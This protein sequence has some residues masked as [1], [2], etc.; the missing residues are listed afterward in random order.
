M[1]ARQG[2]CLIDPLVQ[3][4]SIGQPG[5]EV[6]FRR[7]RHLQGHRPGL[8]YVPKN[9]DGSNNSPIT[10]VDGG[11]KVFDGDFETVSPNE[12][13][14]LGQVHCSVNSNGQIHRVG[15]DLAIGVVKYAE[16]LR[17]GSAGRLLPRPAGHFFRDRIDEGEI[18]QIVGASNGVAYTIE[19]GLGALLFNK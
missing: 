1:T 2:D 16:N 8:A 6:V 4:L 12:N 19:G 9:D 13:G 15:D 7:M 14:V 11:N 17:H 5:Q 18:S 3:E 10:I